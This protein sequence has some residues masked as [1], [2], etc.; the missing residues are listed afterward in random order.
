MLHNEGLGEGVLIWRKVDGPRRLLALALDGDDLR[1]VPL[2]LRKTNLD[3]LLARRRDG[4][5]VA[6][7]EQR[8]IGRP[9]L[10]RAACTSDWKV[11]YRGTGIDPIA[12][13]GHRIGLR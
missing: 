10:I 11:W 2:S 4:I 12:P 3:R 6:P 7:F 1:G 13:G 9:E 5:F 8:D